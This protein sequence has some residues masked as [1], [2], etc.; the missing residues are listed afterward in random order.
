MNL[1]IIQALGIGGAENVFV[2]IAKK[3]LMYKNVVIICLIGCLEDKNNVD[4][5]VSSGF[6]V[7]KIFNC[8]FSEYSLIF[9]LINA[10]S[11][12]ITPLISTFIIITNPGIVKV[13][14]HMPLATYVGVCI[15]FIKKLIGSKI[16]VVETFHT[17]WYLL[18]SHYKLLFSV[19]HRFCDIILVE[20][21][22]EEYHK[23]RHKY[24][25][26][27][28]FYLPFYTLYLKQHEVVMKSVCQPIKILAPMRILFHE[29]PIEIILNGFLHSKLSNNCSY[30]LCFVGGG[31]DF[32]KLEFLVNESKCVNIELF[33]S[34]PDLK[35]S[36]DQYDLCLAALGNSELGVAAIESFNCGIGVVGIGLGELKDDISLEVVRSTFEMTN[37]FNN[38]L[39]PNIIFD[40][41]LK[42][43]IY[44]N[45]KVREGVSW[46]KY[47][48]LYS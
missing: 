21:G 4:D 44:F 15:K 46:S 43:E 41:F 23:F 5:L 45:K 29:K 38:L 24:P 1:H 9:R 25:K 6:K 8:K 18:K 37:L 36:Y 16:L 26:T 3:H 47:N 13:Y 19:I 28:I 33:G 14:T 39:E 17:N 11:F 32:E 12:L 31:K 20:M 22:V 35:Y 42:S 7:K 27:A 48:E 30:K 10:V 34:D 2:Q 40:I